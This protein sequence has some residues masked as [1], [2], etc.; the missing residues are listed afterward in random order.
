MTRELCLQAENT[1]HTGDGEWGEG[2]GGVSIFWLMSIRYMVHSDKWGETTRYT[3][4]KLQQKKKKQFHEILMGYIYWQA[5]ITNSSL[6]G[7]QGERAWAWLTTTRCR[8]T[9]THRHRNT[10][11]HALVKL[12]LDRGKDSP[13]HTSRGHWEQSRCVFWEC[14][15]HGKNVNVRLHTWN[16]HSAVFILLW[17][18]N[19]PTT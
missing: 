10:L 17:C 9:C 19:T 6:Q 7:L 3:D 8:A 11:I 4:R 13:S 5:T 1:L 2:W 16:L 15:R 18:E 12:W 14:Q